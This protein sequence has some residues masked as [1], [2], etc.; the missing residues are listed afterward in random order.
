MVVSLLKASRPHQWIKNLFVAAPLVF[1]HR[2]DDGVATVRT[3]IAIAC[4]CLLS[5]AVYL[6]NDVV[7]IERDQAHPLKRLRPIASGALPISSARLAA[8]A[9]AVTA[10]TA[11]TALSW[12]FGLVT[13]AYAL[14]N[15][16]Y[17]LRWKRVP[18]LDVAC[19]SAGF[20]LRVLG[21][22][23]AIPVAPSGWLLLCTVLLAGLLG[24]GKRAHELRTS[25]EKR[26]TQ[27][28]VLER[29]SPRVLRALLWSLSALTTLAYAAYTQSAHAQTIFGT[30]RL[31][32]TIPFVAVGILRFLRITSRKA[33]AESPTESMLKDGLFVVNLVAYSAAIV[34]IIY[35][36]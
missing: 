15:V 12:R 25:D 27:R 30:R 35:F 14:L 17:S 21:G 7:D 22:A 29:Y 26:S 36:R 32:F 34:L 2:I 5:S 33:D 13:A 3:I 19:I 18:F 16:G 11:A 9:F 1:A 10:I 31:A 28:M 4:F 23:Y 6:L 24:F 20:L 8:L